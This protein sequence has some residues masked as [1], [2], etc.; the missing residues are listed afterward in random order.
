MDNIHQERFAKLG[1]KVVEVLNSEG[2]HAQ[3][4]DNKKE[5][6]EA[7]LE[8]IDFKATV[9]MGGSA[10]LDALGLK[11][12][13]LTRGNTVFNHQG[14]SKE[15]GNKVRHAE[16]T[17]DVFLSSTNALTLNGELVNVDG[18]GNRVAAMLFGPKRVIVIT[19]ANKIVKDEAAARER[20]RMCAAPL[21][22]ARLHCATPCV[23]T[24]MCMD[25]KAPGRICNATVVMHRPMGGSDFHIIVV[26]ESLG[27]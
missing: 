27:Y 18:T 12:I 20:I 1:K 21:N 6:L 11:D 26:G 10:T 19:G 17:S 3:Y 23:A 24:G 15:E 4:V 14:L 13:L 7:A 8:L 16:M 5:A 25:C 9:G 2:F 22:T